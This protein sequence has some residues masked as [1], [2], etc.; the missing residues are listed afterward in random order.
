[1]K[2]DAPYMLDIEEE[3]KRQVAFLTVSLRIASM[4]KWILGAS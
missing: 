3:K 2:I 1:M 4:L